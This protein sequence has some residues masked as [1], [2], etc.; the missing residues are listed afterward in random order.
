MQLAFYTIEDSKFLARVTL[1]PHQNRLPRIGEHVLL[2]ASAQPYGKVT[3]WRVDRIVHDFTS[4]TA[5]NSIVAY[6]TILK[7]QKDNT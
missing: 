1:H 6:V 4:I 7:D 5:N 2:P 3:F